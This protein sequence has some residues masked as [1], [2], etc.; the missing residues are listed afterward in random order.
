MS[1]MRPVSIRVMGEAATPTLMSIV[2]DPKVALTQY[3]SDVW[4]D[5]ARARDPL[6]TKVGPMHT[7]EVDPLP[8]SRVAV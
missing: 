8:R 5:G 1:D 4:S 6:R 7:A 3:V 2:D